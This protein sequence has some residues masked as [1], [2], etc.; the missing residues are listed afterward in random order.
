MNKSRI[1]LDTAGIVTL[2]KE[3]LHVYQCDWGACPTRLNSWQTYKTHIALHCKYSKEHQ[4]GWKKCA[5][6]AHSSREALTV[7]IELSHLSRLPLPC[8]IKDC[9]FVSPRHQLLCGHLLEVHHQVAYQ[10][11]ERSSDVLHQS[12][13]LQPGSAGPSSSCIAFD[14]L[15]KDC[16]AFSTTVLPIIPSP[17]H[18]MMMEPTPIHLQKTDPHQS[19]RHRPLSQLDPIKNKFVIGHN[20]GNTEVEEQEELDCSLNDLGLGHFGFEAGCCQSQVSRL[21]IEGKGKERASGQE[22]RAGDMIVIWPR[23]GSF[24]ASLQLS[25]LPPPDKEAIPLPRKSPPTYTGI[26]LLRKRFTTNTSLGDALTTAAG[27]ITN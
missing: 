20:S 24:S 3:T 26:V 19:N 11:M 22:A 12:S 13:Y 1:L 7:H 17:S 23:H 21:S 6:P 18:T 2:S 15:S 16:A 25:K 10:W 14:K 5:F 27:G 9:V 8:P 4:C